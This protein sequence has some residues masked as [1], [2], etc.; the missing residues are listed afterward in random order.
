MFKIFAKQYTRIS[1]A[2]GLWIFKPQ[3]RTAFQMNSQIK[4][5][6]HLVLWAMG[7]INSSGAL[8][9]AYIVVHHPQ[10]FVGITCI[11]YLLGAEECDQQRTRGKPRQVCGKYGLRLILVSGKISKNPS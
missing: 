10:N 4:L 5:I 7:H 11:N 2:V 1:A 3:T 6:H 9:A 8:C